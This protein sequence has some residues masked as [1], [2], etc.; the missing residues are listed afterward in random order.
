[1]AEFGTLNLEDL[2]LED[3]R[4]NTEAGGGKRDD[5]FISIPKPKQGGT[6]VF[7]VRILPPLKGEKLYQYTRLHMIKGHSVHCPKELVPGKNG[8]VWDRNTYC[9]VCEYY[10][11]LWRKA[12]RLEDMGKKA[13]AEKVKKE[14]R[15]IKPIERYYYN[16]IC[17]QEKDQN[18]EVHQNVGPKVLSIG[19]VL[20]KMIV[21]G[22]RGDREAQEPPVGGNEGQAVDIKNG[23]D[24]VIRMEV[25]GEEQFPNYD[26]T[27][28]AR[29]ASPA[30]KPEE[31]KKWVDNLHDL[32]ALRKPA[33]VEDLDRELA[34]H[35][36]LIDDEEE[37]FDVE[38]FDA[39]FR[40]P[41]TS[42]ST[43]SHV[44]DEEAIESVVTSIDA[45][46]DT[47]SP[48]ETVTPPSRTDEVIDDDAF[49]AELQEMAEDD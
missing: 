37:G 26:R 5:M 20:H 29:E 36:G 45:D 21:R 23:Y 28:F 17:R 2:A 8:P 10:N 4:L 3:Q 31:I 19:K 33:S 41:G 12:D 25:R 30:G 22:L 15:S 38:A 13:E 24:F 1:M 48:V 7:P 27:T 34:R 35:R 9:P 44:T 49:L 46:V 14:A 42:P 40:K 47:E 11:S 43:S 39:K 16:A 32:K 6:T 18:G